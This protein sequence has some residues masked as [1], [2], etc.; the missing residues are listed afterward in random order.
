MLVR[1][2]QSGPAKRSFLRMS[3]PG[4]SIIWSALLTLILINA[5]GGRIGPD[6]VRGRGHGVANAS[7]GNIFIALEAC[8]SRSC[9]S[10]M[11]GFRNLRSWRRRP[12]ICPIIRIHSDRKWPERVVYDTS[13]PTIVPTSTASA[14]VSP[15][16]EAIG[17]APS[18][19][20]VREV[21]AM[22][23]GLPTIRRHPRRK[24]KN[25]SRYA[26]INSPGDARRRPDS[27]WCATRLA[28]PVGISGG[29]DCRHNRK[30][31]DPHSGPDRSRAGTLR[32]KS[33]FPE[34][35]PGRTSPL[36]SPPSP[37]QR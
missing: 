17:G 7:Y 21:F 5:S 18:G 10:W 13:L 9:S 34:R 27:R 33:S 3:G 2:L 8:C 22:L 37:R 20:R 16:P 24:C 32:I 31:L 1:G 35:W 36:P 6:G 30:R 25:R 23:N 26:R 19:T 4:P 12:P 15:A 11:R 29:A 14:E 28:G